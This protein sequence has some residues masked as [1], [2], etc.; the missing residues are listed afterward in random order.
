M[1]YKK[2]GYAPWNKGKTKEEI[3]SHYKN[4]F[5]QG[6][7][8]LTYGLASMRKIIRGY[9]RR[10]KERGHKWDLTEEQFAEITKKNCYYCGAKP[11]N[12]IKQMPYSNGE[13]IYNGIDRIDNTKGYVIDNIVPCCK[14]CNFQKK[15]L[16]L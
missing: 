6:R 10:A 14:F 16:I 15:N 9:K 2:K 5:K 3:K 7:K 12:I 1:I 4:G 13:Y 11:K 8:C